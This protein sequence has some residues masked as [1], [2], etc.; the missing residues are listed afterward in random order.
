MNKIEFNDESKGNELIAL[1]GSRNKETADKALTAFAE[2]ATPLVS[3]VIEQAATTDRIFKPFKYNEDENPSL[4]LDL[5]AYA[6]VGHLSVWGSSYAGGLATNQVMGLQELKFS[7]FPLES[8]VSLLKKY[9]RRSYLNVV[10]QALN[11]MAQELLV[12]KELNG[13]S[14]LLG[15]AV[16]A[17]QADGSDN[18]ITSSV[19]DVLQLEDFN[20]LITL[21]KR[22]N[23]SFA[24]GT[25]TFERFGASD[26]FLSPEMIEQIRAF[27]Y[28][29]MNTRSGKVDTSGATSVPLPDSVREKIYNAGGASEIYGKT[30]HEIWELGVGQ[31]Y[32]T[33][34]GAY[35]GSATIAHS[36]DTF[37][38]AEDEFVLALNLRGDSFWQPIA[39]NAD[40]GATFTVSPDDQW[41]V[42]SDK[43][44]WFTRAE[45]GF[46]AIDGRDITAI[47]V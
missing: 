43:I 46:V 32:N 26:L 13:W 10:A 47:I 20:R 18:I 42:R 5:Y 9:A 1:M 24:N 15:A 25:P 30:L 6:P 11:R 34:F 38:P 3:A 21:S 19:Q 36:S 45:M 12:K 16:Q 28:Q 7:T 27:A 31:K 44:G 2:L 17:R 4:P 37:K 39:K 35:A 8:A 29:P 22:I 14:V 40:S 33:V 23:Q 41:S